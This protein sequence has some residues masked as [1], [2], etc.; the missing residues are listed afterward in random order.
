MI[1]TSHVPATPQSGLREK[2]DDLSAAGF[3][4]KSY[5]AEQLLPTVWQVIEP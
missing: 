3:F 5:D 4:E 1:S 2:A